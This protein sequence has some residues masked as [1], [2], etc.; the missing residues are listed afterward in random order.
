MFFC[1][2]AYLSDSD[3]DLSPISGNLAAVDRHEWR[4]YDPSP[5]TYLKMDAV[6]DQLL[7]L[8]NT[9]ACEQCGAPARMLFSYGPTLFCE[10]CY[11]P[12][13]KNEFADQ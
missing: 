12:E 7:R 3:D 8:T 13:S 6:L 5:E 9:E 10:N 11:H 1:C 4:I 2:S